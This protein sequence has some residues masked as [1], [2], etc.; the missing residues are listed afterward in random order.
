MPISQTEGYFKNPYY[1]FLEEPMLVLLAL[2]TN[3]NFAVNLLK[4]WKNEPFISV[5]FD[6][7]RFSNIYTIS[8]VKIECIEI[9]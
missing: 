5:D 3:S 7:S 2:K 1:H 8:Y 6:E 9:N 4:C